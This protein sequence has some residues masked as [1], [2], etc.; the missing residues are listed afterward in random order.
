M[1]VHFNSSMLRYVASEIVLRCYVLLLEEIYLL[2]AG[3]IAYFPPLPPTRSSTPSPSMLT[4]SNF[5]MKPYSHVTCSDN[6]GD[7]HSEMKTE[8]EGSVK[9]DTDQATLPPDDP[10]LDISPSSKVFFNFLYSNNTLQ[11]TEAR[12]GLVCPWCGLSCKKIYS[13][14]KHMSLCHP[15]FQFT[16]TVGVVEREGMKGGGVD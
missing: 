11:Q 13:L 10:C 9:E 12:D 15:R 8:P 1:S 14:L 5:P 7:T 3:P 2:S 16:Y 4:P 6:A